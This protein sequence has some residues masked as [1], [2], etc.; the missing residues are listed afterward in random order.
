MTL[1]TNEIVIVTTGWST[2]TSTTTA[3]ATATTTTTIA[4]HLMI[5]TSPS[6]SIFA[7]INLADVAFTTQFSTSSPSICK[8]FAIYNMVEDDTHAYTHAQTDTRTTKS[9]AG[10]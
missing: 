9:R 4:T 10:G 1:V 7:S 6:W 2:T 3:T 5:T 8:I